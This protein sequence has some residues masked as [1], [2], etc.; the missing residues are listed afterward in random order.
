MKNTAGKKSVR[1][2]KH[3]GVMPAGRRRSAVTSHGANRILFPQSHLMRLAA[4][5]RSRARKA[6]RRYVGSGRHMKLLGS[7]RLI[8]KARDTRKSSVRPLRNS[9]SIALRTSS[10]SVENEI[11][12]VQDRVSTFRAPLI[13]D[14]PAFLGVMI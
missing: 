12:A 8:S 1:E 4:H 14:L 3:C 9:A 2:E 6:D 7:P 13:I 5:R 10:A 11:A